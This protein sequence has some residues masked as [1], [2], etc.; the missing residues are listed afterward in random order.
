MINFSKIFLS[1]WVVVLSTGSVLWA[2]GSKL[3]SITA[4][5]EAS[6]DLALKVAMQMQDEA[7]RV[8]NAIN[9]TK[10]ASS[11]RN[12]CSF[13]VELSCNDKIT[14]SKCWDGIINQDWEQCDWGYDC[15]ACR[16]ITRIK[17]SECWNGV[18]E[19]WE[20]CDQQEWF[21]WNTYCTMFCTIESK[22]SLEKTWPS[23]F[24]MGNIL[25][26]MILKS[27][28]YRKK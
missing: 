4:P 25:S 22:K 8:E 27:K 19:K 2:W 1:L 24:S 28:V 26:P 21:D 15:N 17:G 23:D 3:F 5:I 16:I 20:A 11:D 12:D 13:K 9:G 6:P 14:D 10:I 7:K 18:V